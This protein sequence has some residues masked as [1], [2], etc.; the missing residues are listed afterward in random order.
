MSVF[1]EILPQI[2][3]RQGDKK[4]SCVRR[5]E[6]SDGSALAMENTL[7]NSIMPGFSGVYAPRCTRV[8]RM[9]GFRAG[10]TLVI[11]WYETT[12]TP[13]EA[14]VSVSTWYTPNIVT[15]DLDGKIVSGPDTDGVHFW[16]VVAGSNKTGKATCKV[17]VETAYDSFDVNEVMA[18]TWHVNSNTLSN[19]GNARPDS[20]ILLGAP[21]TRYWKQGNL[22]YIN[23]ALAYSG[24]DETWNEMLKSRKGVNCARTV[25]VFDSTGAIDSTVPNRVIADF[26]FKQIVNGVATTTA[27]ESRRIIP[28]ADF[29][30]L[31]GLVSWD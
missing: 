2:I 1:Q 12:R 11:A 16:R 10:R 21:N 25:R 20:M 17:T 23:Y 27:P 7:Y 15:T 19:I 26:L 14:T 30:D 29:S 8:R 5:F 31:D 24:P 4:W 3:E 6:V 28:A 18:R 13:G 9:K 22:W